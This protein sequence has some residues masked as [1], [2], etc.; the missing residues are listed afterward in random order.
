LKS[1]LKFLKSGL[2]SMKPDQDAIKSDLKTLGTLYILQIPD[3]LSLD[4]KYLKSVLK[5]LE[6][7]KSGLQ[8]SS[9]N[10]E[11]LKSVLKLSQKYTI[12]YFPNRRSVD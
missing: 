1:D 8:H 9:L 11:Y 12:S 4:L 2:K 5:P 6:S 7:L 10:L 3:Y